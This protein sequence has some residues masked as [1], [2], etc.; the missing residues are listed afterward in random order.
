MERHAKYLDWSKISSY[1]KLSE[2]FIKR[3][4]DKLDLYNISVYQILSDEFIRDNPMLMIYP[5]MNI[6]YSKYFTKGGR[7][8]LFSEFK[9]KYLSIWDKDQEITWNE[10]LQKV[11]NK[12]DDL[13]YAVKVLIE[14]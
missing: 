8:K 9:E 7:S 1:Q 13:L 10:F 4:M 11:C 2:E 6:I 3:N 12:H 14:D 5:R